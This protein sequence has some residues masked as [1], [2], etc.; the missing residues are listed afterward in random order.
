MNKRDEPPR[1][2]SV[3]NTTI[4]SALMKEF[5]Y[6]SVMQVA[7]WRVY[8]DEH[9]VLDLLPAHAQSLLSLFTVR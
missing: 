9:L 1:L 7:G 4:R 6:S 2:Q 8:P 3:Y 5:G